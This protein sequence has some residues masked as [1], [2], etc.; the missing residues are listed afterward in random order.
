[1]HTY[2]HTHTHTH[3]QMCDASVVLRLGFVG[4]ATSRWRLREHFASVRIELQFPEIW[5]LGA[6]CMGFTTRSALLDLLS[7]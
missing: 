4:S 1:M 2:I 7:A 3:A 6:L 5:D